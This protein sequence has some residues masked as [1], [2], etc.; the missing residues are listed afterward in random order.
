MFSFEHDVP[1]LNKRPIL[2]PIRHGG[3]FP[4]Y[5]AEVTHICEVKLPILVIRVYEVPQL[6][7]FF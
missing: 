1:Q 2:L 3:Y 4:E 5:S 7:D 6:L